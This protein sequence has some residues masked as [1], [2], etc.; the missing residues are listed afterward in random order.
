MNDFITNALLHKTLADLARETP[1]K[2]VLDLLVEAMAYTT[3]EKLQILRPMVFCP[4][5][6]ANGYAMDAYEE[7]LLA[8]PEDDQ[9]VTEYYDRFTV[10]EDG[11]C[12][13]Q[14]EAAC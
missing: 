8:L 3:E 6:E 9:R 4:W 13:A 7:V 11:L 5:G 10:G 14:R 1:C 12:K 2:E